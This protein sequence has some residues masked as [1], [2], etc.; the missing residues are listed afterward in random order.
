MSATTALLMV[1]AIWL[2]TGLLFGLA[3]GRH[4]YD[5]FA[6]W[7]LGTVL[8]PLVIP[9]ALSAVHRPQEAPR[10]VKEGVAATGPVDLLVGV[11]GS[12]QAAAALTAALDL[13]GSRLG[14][15]TLVAVTSLLH[16][17]AS[18]PQARL[19]S[20]SSRRAIRTYQTSRNRT[21]NTEM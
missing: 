16:G 1:A 9:I 6:W 12:P 21:E 3:M 4:G 5:P 18:S 15:L 10:V 8:G 7:L 20:W 2:S 14:R 13:V 11:D 17:D 19:P